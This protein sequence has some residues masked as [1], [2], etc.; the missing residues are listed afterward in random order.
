VDVDGKFVDEGMC[1][2]AG[3][4]GVA[5]ADGG[6]GSWDEPDGGPVTRRSGFHFVWIPYGAFGGFGTYAPGYVRPGPGGGDGAGHASPGAVTRGGFGATGA[7]HA[8]PSSSA[9]S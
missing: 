5:A 8:A 2:G 7:A 9:G 3:A 4:D 1:V 6:T